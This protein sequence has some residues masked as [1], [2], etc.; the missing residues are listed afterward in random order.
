ME[1]CV[2]DLKFSARALRDLFFPR[3]CLVCGRFLETGEQDV[4]AACL[5]ELPLTWQ[6]D[7]GQNAAFERVACRTPSVPTAK[8]GWL[9]RGDPSAA[10]TRPEK[11]E[12]T[13]FVDML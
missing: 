3:R 7:I 11:S 9:P 5:E 2:S 12:P 1:N 10:W 4:C 13:A 8:T 6:W